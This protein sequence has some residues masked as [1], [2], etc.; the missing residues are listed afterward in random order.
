MVLVA[1]LLVILLGVAAAVGFPVINHLFNHGIVIETLVG[2]NS[3]DWM[4]EF[5]NTCEFVLIACVSLF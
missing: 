1:V 5:N 2:Q 3:A 4:K